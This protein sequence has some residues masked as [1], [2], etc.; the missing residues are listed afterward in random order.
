MHFIILRDVAGN[1][2]HLCDSKEH[3]VKVTGGGSPFRELEGSEGN[4]LPTPLAPKG[5]TYAFNA[6]K[7]G[8]VYPLVDRR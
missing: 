6:K 2:F 5:E 7:N 3:Y 4:S 1:S 8:K